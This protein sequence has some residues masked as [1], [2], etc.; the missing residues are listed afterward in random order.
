LLITD[1]RFSKPIFGKSVPVKTAT[2]ISFVRLR[3][4]GAAFRQTQ[5][6]IYGQVRNYCFSDV[7]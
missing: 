3:I 7:R 6:F 4:I 1:D 5:T 2:Q